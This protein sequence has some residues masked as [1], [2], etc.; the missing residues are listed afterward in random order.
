M[1]LDTVEFVLWAEKKFGIDI[2]DEDVT[3]QERIVPVLRF[4]Q[5]SLHEVGISIPEL[6]NYFSP[7]TR[8]EP[9]QSPP[10]ALG[11]LLSSSTI[12]IPAI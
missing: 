3:H 4:H 7:G 2:P 9:G 10:V 5:E 8:H 1:G 12:Q 11:S 6:D